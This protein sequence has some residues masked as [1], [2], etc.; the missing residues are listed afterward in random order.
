MSV[1]PKE[2]A[3]E[4]KL[5]R[6]SGHGSHSAKL[7]SVARNH[8]PS[9]PC[10]VAE[11]RRLLAEHKKPLKSVRRFVSAAVDLLSWPVFVLWLAITIHIGVSL[12]F[13]PAG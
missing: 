8:F 4:A 5:F 6:E 3:K 13:V 2:I 9:E 11:E 7:L 12:L 1:S 10:L